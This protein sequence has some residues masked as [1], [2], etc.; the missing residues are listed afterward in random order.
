MRRLIRAYL[1]CM[2]NAGSAI[3][4]PLF[5]CCSM[6]CGRSAALFSV[7]LTCL[8]CFQHLLVLH[9]RLRKDRK[10]V[11]KGG[12]LLREDQSSEILF[13]CP[14]EP[15]EDI[16][17]L[18]SCLPSCVKGN[19]TLISTHSAPR[20]ALYTHCK[21]NHFHSSSSLHFHSVTLERPRSATPLRYS[22]C[23]PPL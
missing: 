9:I 14:V 3:T 15:V 18:P 6:L 23:T 10:T 5:W 12:S 11:Q 17:L 8:V 2:T 13:C 21:A 7:I 22:R 19:I 4:E 20:N 1:H 16:F